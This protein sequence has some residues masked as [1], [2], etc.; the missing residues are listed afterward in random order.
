[1]IS[2]GLYLLGAILG[3]ATI[4][5]VF[6][7]AGPAFAAACGAAACFCF[8]GMVFYGIFP[9]LWATLLSVMNTAFVVGLLHYLDG[10]IGL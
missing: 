6:F 1:M 8:S 5:S 10:R 9:P 7:D 2:A 4:G 3:M